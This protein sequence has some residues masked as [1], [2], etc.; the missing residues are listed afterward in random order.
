[1]A[2]TRVWTACRRSAWSSALSHAVESRRTATAAGSARS[3]PR[4]HPKSIRLGVQLIRLPLHV[5]CNGIAR[6]VDLVPTY[7]RFAVAGD[8]QDRGRCRDRRLHQ[9]DRARVLEGDERDALALVRCG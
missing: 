6:A 7:V 3:R 5:L 9:L 8:E 2:S 4:C 1:M